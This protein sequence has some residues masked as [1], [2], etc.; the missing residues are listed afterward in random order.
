MLSVAAV[1]ARAADAPYPVTVRPA[2]ELAVSI[3]YTAGA[4]VVSAN[5]A[6]LRA[7]VTAPVAAVSADVGARVS[8]ND[9]LVMLDDTDARL[10]LARARAD[11]AA[12]DGEIRLARSRLDRANKLAP[13]NYVST[14]ELEDLDARL[15]VLK[16]QRDGLAVAV[17]IAEETL[18]DTRIR[19]PFDGVVTQ[20]DA[21]VGSLVRDGDPLITVV[22]SSDREVQ[23]YVAPAQ[24]AA[25]FAADEI[26]LMADGERWPLVLRRV[27][28]VID[29]T[30]GLQ[31]ARL[32]FVDS[33]APIGLS[34]TLQWQSRRQFYPVDLVQRRGSQLG[35]F[36]ADGRVARFHAAPDGQEG[37][38]LRLALPPSS[39]VVVE[40]RSRL[41]DGD[42]IEIVAP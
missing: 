35:L 2:G 32:G 1:S 41:Q 20:R 8:K 22:Q 9:P 13:D 26:T 12:V 15:A 6:T 16:A 27:T 4:D 18:S 5:I 19:A 11:L 21:Q 3:Q 14:D 23:A 40:G 33:L 25:L 10:A 42:P 24:V 34:G 30:T 36:T 7:E 17:G 37:R 39:Q 38:P 29:I 28:D 31:A